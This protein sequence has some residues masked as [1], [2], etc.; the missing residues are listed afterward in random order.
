V[1][2]YNANSAAFSAPSAIRVYAAPEGGLGTLFRDG[3]VLKTSW[4]PA[5]LP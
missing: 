4:S 5:R 2:K 1:A 3:D